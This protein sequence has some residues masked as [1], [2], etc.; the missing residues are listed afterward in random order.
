MGVAEDRERLRAHAALQGWEIPNLSAPV[1]PPQQTPSDVMRIPTTEIS[2]PRSPD[3]PSKKEVPQVMLPHG[4]DPGMA[5]VHAGYSHGSP[6]ALGLDLPSGVGGGRLDRSIDLTGVV[7]KGSAPDDKPAPVFPK[8]VTEPAG[9]EP[10]HAVNVA[11]QN[12]AM[13]D[14]KL[15]TEMSD[16]FEKQ[17]TALEEGK[18]A[19]T[20]LGESE[21]ITDQLEAQGL[22]DESDLLGKQ[23]DDTK[24]QAKDAKGESS[25][26]LDHINSLSEAQSKKKIDPS[27]GWANT[28]D[29]DKIRLGI[30]N[31]LGGFLM[32][33]QHRDSNP[34]DLNK[35]LA[36]INNKDVESQKAEYEA[37]GDHI[38]GLKSNYAEAM[39][40]T[41]DQAKAA[42][43]AQGMGLRQVQLAT[44]SLAKASG[45]ATHLA[46]ADA[47]NAKTDID[48][49][50]V[51]AEATAEKMRANKFVPAHQAMAG[52]AAPLSAKENA[53]TV[54]GPD[55]QLYI[56][57]DAPSRKVLETKS[58]SYNDTEDSLRA[59]QA[60]LAKVGAMDIAQAKLGITTDAMSVAQSTYN[61]ALSG[62]RQAQDDGVWKKSESSML[63]QTLTPPDHISGNAK[64]Q[65]RQALAL[66]KK[67]WHNTLLAS[68][69]TPYGPAPAGTGA[70]DPDAVKFK[71]GL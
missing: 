64:L 57:K 69:A 58:A 71:P 17:K 3:M 29:F 5:G 53:L 30:A 40:A 42:S 13:V 45:S 60:A 38:S 36:E 49:G 34:F 18:S 68:A 6:Q 8:P 7:P 65:S 4:E 27:H 35:R 41:G 67:A 2:A 31:V 56:A 46:R 22:K 16:A 48:I 55:G 54:S 11:A 47:L 14:P 23:A 39:K 32:G 15:Q 1:S 59:Y 70:V 19:T 9:A 20:K 43:V 52:G 63:A 51:A 37:A 21:G 28:S 44:S 50:K 61:H 24:A 62:L 10:A 66:A 33:Y 12:V 26:L 25:K